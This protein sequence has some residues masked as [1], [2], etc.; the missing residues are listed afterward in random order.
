L[1]LDADALFGNLNSDLSL[2]FG[3]EVTELTLLDLFLDLLNLGSL[4]HA[5]DLGLLLDHIL[6]LV[7]GGT[8]INLAYC[9]AHLLGVLRVLDN[10]LCEHELSLLLGFGRFR[11]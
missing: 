8:G 10:T 11:A 6:G 2:L 5:V 1:C 7:A 9:D 3:R 4:L